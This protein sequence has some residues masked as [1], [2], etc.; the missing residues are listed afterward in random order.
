MTEIVEDMT[1]LERTDEYA[2]A[3]SVGRGCVAHICEL[4]RLQNE[5]IDDEDW[6]RQD[7]IRDRIL[8]TPYS[9][10]VRTGWRPA[11]REFTAQ[12]IEEVKFT[13][14]GGGPAVRIVAQIEDSYGNPEIKDIEVQVQDW[15]LPWR[16]LP[17]G[18][19]T[20]KILEWFVQMFPVTEAY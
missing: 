15:F 12:D 17:V 19:D 16:V 9:I 5:A 6:S 4:N 14:A 13:L 20:A 18:N 10:E 3:L 2:N 1:I 7:D 11:Y 8:E